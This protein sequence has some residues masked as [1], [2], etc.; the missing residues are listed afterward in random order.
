MSQRIPVVVRT[1]AGVTNNFKIP[2]FC[3]YSGTNGR[4][5]R[6]PYIHIDDNNVF[7]ALLLLCVIQPNTNSVECTL[8]SRKM[9]S[10]TDFFKVDCTKYT[11]IKL[12][13]VHLIFYCIKCTV[14][15][16]DLG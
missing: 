13:G 15:S 5:I 3:G 10:Q 8:F 4:S 1:A 7:H 6:R 11:V 12:S 14:R 9:T 16:S 2:V